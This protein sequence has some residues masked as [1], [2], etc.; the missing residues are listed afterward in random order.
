MLRW[1]SLLV[2]SG[3]MLA[4]Y[5]LAQ[6]QILPDPASGK[7]YVLRTV[8]GKVIERLTPAGARFMIVGVPGGESRTGWVKRI[9]SRLVF[10]DNVGRVTATA[11]EELLPAEAPISAIATVRDELGNPIGFLTRY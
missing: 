5:S 8:G 3:L 7:G 9:G 10:F 6:A 2:G 11:R 1:S 4:I